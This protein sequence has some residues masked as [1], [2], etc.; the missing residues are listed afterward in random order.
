M[1]T[2]DSVG[3]TQTTQRRW[4]Y[5]VGQPRPLSDWEWVASRHRHTE[6]GGHL[7]RLCRGL[8]GILARAAKR[9]RVAD[10]YTYMHNVAWLVA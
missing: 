6:D 4:T 10:M 8:H 9:K 3:V 2:E 7:L 1:K 5:G